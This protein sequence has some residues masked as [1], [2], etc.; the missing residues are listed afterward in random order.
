MSLYERQRNIVVELALAGRTA[1]YTADRFDCSISTIRWIKKKGIGKLVDG[2]DCLA[3]F[4]VYQFPYS[5]GRPK[6]STAR[7]ERYHGRLVKR[8]RFRSLDQ[9]THEFVTHL[10][11][12]V[13]K[14]TVSRRL[15]GQAIYSRIAVQNWTLVLRTGSDNN[16]DGVAE[17][18]TGQ[19]QTTGPAYFS[20]MNQCSTL[21]VVTE[22]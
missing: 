10:G 18:S 1:Q 22:G 7:D 16:D 3:I 20:P 12:P 17:P 13:S 15:H 21:H 14:R 9:V 19:Y 6:R 2:K 4:A 8:I 5:S 11:N